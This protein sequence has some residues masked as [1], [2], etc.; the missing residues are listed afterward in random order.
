MR[1]ELR[2]ELRQDRRLLGREVIFF[3]L[4]LENVEQAA[5]ATIERQRFVLDGCGVRRSIR[6]DWGLPE[7][8]I[9][10]A[11]NQLV[12]ANDDGRYPSC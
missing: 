9:L 4:V 5:C 6:V 12:L 7:A 2:C 1:K 11:K 10:H 3:T 8:I